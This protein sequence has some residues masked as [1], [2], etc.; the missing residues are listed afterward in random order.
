VERPKLF[1]SS[2]RSSYRVFYRC[3]LCLI[4]STSTSI[5]AGYSYHFNHSTSVIS[6][7]ITFKCMKLYHIH[8]MTAQ[9]LSLQHKVSFNKH[10]AIKCIRIIYITTLTLCNRFRHQNCIFSPSHMAFLIKRNK[11]KHIQHTEQ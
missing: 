7:I 5:V 9:L 1:I 11:I 4:P 2:L 8:I 6:G 10:P 3:P